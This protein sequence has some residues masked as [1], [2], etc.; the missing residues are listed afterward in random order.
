M[1]ALLLE[2]YARIE[3]Y[4]AAEAG[5]W[6]N[7]QPYPYEKA[8]RNAARKNKK[9]NQ[10]VPLLAQAGLAHHVTPEELQARYDKSNE[11]YAKRIA[12]HINQEAEKARQLV[13]Q[14]LDL[15]GE[16]EMRKLEAYRMRVYSRSLVYDLEF[17]KQV[18][19]N[20]KEEA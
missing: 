12:G 14:V 11:A 13:A 3:R 20:H 9:E 16:D 6:E 17:W 2:I 4:R 18:I 7:W 5:P 10:A 1:N 19:Q 15:V 8:V